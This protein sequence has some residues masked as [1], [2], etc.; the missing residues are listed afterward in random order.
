[1]TYACGY[2]PCINTYDETQTSAVRMP[3][4]VSVDRTMKEGGG[5]S[6]LVRS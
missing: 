1:M 6:V 4:I 5:S 2:L 3:R